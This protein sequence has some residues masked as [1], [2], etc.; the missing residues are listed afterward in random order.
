MA[1]SQKYAYIYVGIIQCQFLSNLTIIVNS[2][3][4][5]H[6]VAI[7]YRYILYQKN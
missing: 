1:L 4:G 5:T 7:G 6:I 2:N 3:L